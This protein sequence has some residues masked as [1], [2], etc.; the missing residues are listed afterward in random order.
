VSRTIIAA[1]ALSAFSIVV[2]AYTF[3]LQWGLSDGEY[4]QER[5]ES[6]REQLAYERKRADECKPRCERVTTHWPDGGYTTEVMCIDGQRACVSN[7]TGG[8]P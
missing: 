3:G 7:T 5:S 6:L 4:W 1:L 2:S 8:C